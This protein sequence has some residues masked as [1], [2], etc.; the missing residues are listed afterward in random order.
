ML[1]RAS[2]P[3]RMALR[4]C[5]SARA[6]P[7]GP[8]RALVAKPTAPTDPDDADA[9]VDLMEQ[10]IG[11]H[12]SAAS[13]ALRQMPG[14]DRAKRTFR[15]GQAGGAATPTA[16]AGALGT[17]QPAE[18]TGPIARLASVRVRGDDA[19]EAVRAEYEAQVRPMYEAAEGCLGAQLLFDGNTR[20]ATSLTLWAS[21]QH[22]EAASTTERYRSAM[23]ALGVHFVGAPELQTLQLHA[24]THALPRPSREG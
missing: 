3:A 12:R 21:A 14:R 20:T 24:S 9:D 19:I 6:P 13:A 22:L 1:M 4:R 11:L 2:A 18:Y 8:A 15:G 17:S 10:T 7:V 5:G 23:G 16:A